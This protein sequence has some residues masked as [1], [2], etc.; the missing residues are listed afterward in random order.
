MTMR[1]LKI[2]KKQILILLLFSFVGAILAISHGVIFDLKI[3]EIGRLSSGGV[4]L[5][6]IVVFLL[7]LLMEWIFDLDNERKIEEL[8]REIEEVKKRVR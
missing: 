4:I 2:N 6:M 1:N 3:S 7:L 8:S 5:T